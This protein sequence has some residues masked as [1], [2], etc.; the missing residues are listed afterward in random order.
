MQYRDITYYESDLASNAIEL[1]TALLDRQQGQMHVMV[2]RVVAAGDVSYEG[3][4]YDNYGVTYY[5]KPVPGTPGWVFGF[6]LSDTDINNVVMDP[7]VSSLETVRTYT[8]DEIYEMVYHNLDLMPLELTYWM[9]LKL[10]KDGIHFSRVTNNTSAFKVAPLGFTDPFAYLREETSS[11]VRDLVYSINDYTLGDSI[12]TSPFW[13]LIPPDIYFS[14][15]LDLYWIPKFW[16]PNT[17]TYNKTLSVFL[18]TQSGVLRMYPGM[19][20]AGGRSYDPRD[21]AWY[22]RAVTNYDK[23]SFSLPPVDPNGAGLVCRTPYCV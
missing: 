14:S 10:L 2:F 17:P 20:Q 1:R 13:P 22:L 5:W 9:G 21:Q 15:L 16:N 4:R 3:T 11:T 19:L 6:C 7:Q 18:G 12:P 23:I 8:D